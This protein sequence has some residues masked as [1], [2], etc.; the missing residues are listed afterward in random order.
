MVRGYSAPE[1]QT[2]PNRFSEM[3]IWCQEGNGKS[4]GTVRNYATREMLYV[5]ESS[6]DVFDQRMKALAEYEDP[7]MGVMAEAEKAENNRRAKKK[8]A[9]TI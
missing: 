6:G 3:A 1:F 9:R 5:S 4:C 2:G 8:P 7:V